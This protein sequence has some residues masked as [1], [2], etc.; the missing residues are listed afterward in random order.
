MKKQK[1]ILSTDTRESNTIFIGNVHPLVTVEE[2]N[3][4]FLNSG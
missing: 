1:E 3:N 2:L 4:F